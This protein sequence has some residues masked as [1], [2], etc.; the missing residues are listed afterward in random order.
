M[1]KKW[2]ATPRAEGSKTPLPNLDVATARKIVERS[3]SEPPSN[4]YFSLKLKQALVVLA[5]YDE[6]KK[7]PFAL[8]D[9]AGAGDADGELGSPV[10]SFAK[11]KVPVMMK[12]PGISAEN[13]V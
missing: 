2:L 9:N 11:P 3:T 10:N 6:E 1:L 12:L 4:Y 8:A 13:E 7:A 5:N